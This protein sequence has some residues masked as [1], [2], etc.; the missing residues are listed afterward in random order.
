MDSRMTFQ[1]AEEH[2]ADLRRSADAGRRFAPVGDAPAHT[3]VIAL[4]PAGPDEAE[5]LERLAALDSARPLAGESLVAVVD[6]K[7]VAAISLA[8][9]RVIADPLAP[10]AEAR[11]LLHTRAAQLAHTPRRP[12]RRFRPRL[13]PRFA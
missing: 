1:I 3:P 9:G 13:R 11:A 6:G 7:L 5:Q 8:S 4:R 2:I 10:T 12:W